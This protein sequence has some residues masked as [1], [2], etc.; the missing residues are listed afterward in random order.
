[1]SGMSVGISK[2]LPRL[3]KMVHVPVQ[4]TWYNIFYSDIDDVSI[5]DLS[6]LPS[7]ISFGQNW[8]RAVTALGAARGEKVA[9][10]S[11]LGPKARKAAGPSFPWRPQA[12]L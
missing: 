8:L 10:G 1:M 2:L 9:V 12:S 6:S 3:N 11:G 4:C 5:G 7:L